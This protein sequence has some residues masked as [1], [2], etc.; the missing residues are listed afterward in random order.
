MSNNLECAYVHNRHRRDDPE[1]T[2]RPFGTFL[3]SPIFP[4]PSFPLFRG[5]NTSTNPLY[6]SRSFLFPCILGPSP[7]ADGSQ[8]TPVFTLGFTDFPPALM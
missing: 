3:T 1:D 6:V 7:A 8:A 4:N 5:V 2:T